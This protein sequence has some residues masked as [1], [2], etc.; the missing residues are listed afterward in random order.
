[1]PVDHKTVIPGEIM[2]IDGKKQAYMCQ[3]GKFNF[4]AVAYYTLAFKSARL[5]G[6][7]HKTKSDEWPSGE[8]WKIREY[9]SCEEVQTC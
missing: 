1:M 8:A 6:M 2:Q 7:I 9:V 4:K 5:R 3:E